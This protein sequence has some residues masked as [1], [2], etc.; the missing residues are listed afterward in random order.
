LSKSAPP[1]S[2][3]EAGRF[4]TCRKCYKS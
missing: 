4:A 3:A 2:M 1:A